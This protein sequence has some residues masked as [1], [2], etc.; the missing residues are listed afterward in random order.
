MALESHWEKGGETIVDDRYTLGFPTL[1]PGYEEQA[2][3]SFRDS[4]GDSYE[5][6]HVYGRSAEHGERGPVRLIDENLSYW[7]VTSSTHEEDRWLSYTQA[8]KQRKRR[9]TFERFSSLGWKQAELRDL[10][11]V[12]ES[13]SSIKHSA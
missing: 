3:S 7:S 11:R 12:G 2:V 8:R 4:T 6:H 5:L 10:L 9:L 1:P 13:E